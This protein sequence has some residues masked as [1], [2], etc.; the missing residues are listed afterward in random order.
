MCAHMGAGWPLRGLY[1]EQLR[2]FLNGIKGMVNL[3]KFVC[4]L[5]N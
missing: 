1:L 3:V 5:Y 2:C 4:L